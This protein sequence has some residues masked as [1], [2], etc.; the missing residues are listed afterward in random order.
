MLHNFFQQEVMVVSGLFERDSLLYLHSSRFIIMYSLPGFSGSLIP[1]EVDVMKDHDMI[2][3][4]EILL[5]G[6]RY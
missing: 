1:E 6:T 3:I 4:V 2:Y 5:N